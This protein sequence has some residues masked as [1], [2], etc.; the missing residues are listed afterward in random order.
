MGTRAPRAPDAWLDGE[1]RAGE[2]LRE[3]I[4]EET[5]WPE[6]I[7]E[8]TRLPEHIVEVAAHISHSPEAELVVEACVPEQ[9]EH[10]TKGPPP[11]EPPP[12]PTPTMPDGEN[13]VA[14]GGDAIES[15]PAFSWDAEEGPGYMG[16]TQITT[17][18]RE[19]ETG[20]A[21]GAA[22]DKTSALSGHTSRVGPL[23][24]EGDEDR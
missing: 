16:H 3:H 20:A 21:R 12:G 13:V 11:P 1:H 7:A 24:I 5:R 6:H 8:E 10:A 2:A 19:N 15:G 4:A 18:H 9:R 22:A 17:Y 14:A 23:I